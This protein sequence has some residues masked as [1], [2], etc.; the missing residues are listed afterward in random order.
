MVVEE[1]KKDGLD[2]IKLKE[3][4]SSHGFAVI[5]ETPESIDGWIG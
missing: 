3:P 2:A 5:N 1:T 4:H